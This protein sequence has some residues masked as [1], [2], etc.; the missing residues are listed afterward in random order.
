MTTPSH[1]ESHRLVTTATQRLPLSEKVGYALGDTASNLYFQFFNLFL[2]YYYTD[3]FGL[4][5][6][7]IGT[8]FLI[9]NFWDAVNDPLMGAVADRNQSRFG[10]YRPFLLWFC[11]PYGV[12]GY[13]MFVNPD[14]GETGKLLFAYSTFIGFKMIYTA[15]NV[16]YSAMMGVLTEDA[17]QRL[18]LS[19]FR[20]LGGIGG[21]FIVS[22]LVRPLVGFFG[23]D[24]ELLG[25]QMTMAVFGTASVALFMVT[26]FTTKERLVP[27]DQQTDIRSDLGFLL[28]NPPWLAIAGASLCVMSNIAVRGAVTVHYFKY[29][30]S[31]GDTVVFSV[32]HPDSP[33]HLDFDRTTLFLSSGMLAFLV[34]VALTE[35]VARGFGKKWGLILCS[36]LN[37]ASLLAFFFIPADQVGLIYAVNLLG[38][39]V[40]GPMPALNWALYTDVADYG[41]WRF[42][43]RATGLVFSAAMLALKMGLTI[44]GAASG[45]LLDIYGFIPNQEQVPEAVMAI[46]ALF[47]LLPGGL[48][49]GA[50]GFL[51]LLPLSEARMQAI[52]AEL[53]E[54]RREGS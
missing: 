11:V 38:N 13:L 18:S 24:D 23:G 33:F 26:F 16:P 46:R 3:V 54:R 40:A 28:R 43:S 53:G 31:F 36:S 20:F 49:L 45:W 29:Y 42:G 12:S 7:A 51:L 27:Q 14:F 47:S 30:L 52:Q 41:E 6:A 48:A 32:G 35:I 39:L 10:K 22:L 8:M 34:G 37:A 4:D 21:G 19:K 25:F 17:D 9:A 1:P 5:P 2:F 50:V 15:I 44:G